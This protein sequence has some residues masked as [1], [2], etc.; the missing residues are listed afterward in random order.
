MKPVVLVFSF[1]LL[2]ANAADTQRFLDVYCI[3]STFPVGCYVF[4]TSMSLVLVA[5][6]SYFEN[7]IGKF[8]NKRLQETFDEV[9][10]DDDTAHAV[11]HCQRLP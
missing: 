11:K 10:V 5:G 4:C 3:S 9:F 6:I 1:L 2:S 7:Y 8:N